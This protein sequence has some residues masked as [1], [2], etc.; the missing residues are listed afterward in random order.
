M[1]YRIAY[2]VKIFI[3]VMIVIESLWGQPAKIRVACIG[4]SITWGGLGDLSYPQQLQK[5]LGAQYDVRNYGV[6]ARTLLK[7][8]DYPYWKEPEFIASRY[9]DPHIVIIKLGTNDSKPQNWVYKNQFF[10]DYMDLVHEYR[11]FNRRPQIYVCFPVPVFKTNWGIN[12]PVVHDQIIPLIDSVRNESHTFLIDFYTAMKNDGA[13]F[14]DGVHP[15]EIGYEKMAQLV[16]DTIVNGQSG[17]IRYFY[18][19]KDTLYKNESTVLYWNTSKSSQV[20]LNGTPVKAID[21]LVISPKSSTTYILKTMGDYIDSIQLYIQYYPPG[22]I[23]M[24]NITPPFFEKGM[25]DTIQVQWKTGVGSKVTLNKSIVSENDIRA[26]TQKDGLSYTL[27]VTGDT[28]ETKTIEIPLVTSNSFNRALYRHASASSTE[29]GF[30]PGAINDGLMETIWKSEYYNSQS[31]SIDLGKMV[32]I[33]KI[34]LQWGSIFG[35]RYAVILSNEKGEAT[36][37]YDTDA[38]DGEA[39]SISNLSGTGRYVK[40]LCLKSNIANKPYSI[41]EVEVYGARNLL[42]TEDEKTNTLANQYD[43]AQNFPNPFNPATVINYQLPL[44]N[45]TTLKVYDLL[46]KEIIILV[47]EEKNAGIYSVQMNSAKLSNGI[48]FYRLTSGTFSQ[49]KKM[50]LLK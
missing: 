15:N 4:N 42:Y 24:F 34:I 37:I 7:N 19:K 13:L 38:G 14:P 21:S 20:W 22:K 41:K 10:S 49:S 5:K 30:M 23:Q 25:E 48:Y 27:Q 46:G 35:S 45:Y 44:R 11:K 18:A 3:V 1:N 32:D 6:S 9:F 47:N 2:T 28:I 8:G 40:I 50:I 17:V 43:L 36:S 29:W 39:D 16:Y 31:V 12:E 26:V 33:Q